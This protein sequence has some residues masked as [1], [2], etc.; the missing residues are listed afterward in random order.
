MSAS[1]E[2]DIKIFKTRK[3]LMTDDALIQD[4]NH[5]SNTFKNALEETLREGAK[6]LLQQAIE[7]EVD[8][9]IEMFKELKGNDNKRFVIRNGYLPQRV[10]QTGIGPIDVKQPR[11]RDKRNG[12]NFNSLIL[13]KYARKTPSI[14]TVIPTLYLKGISTSDFTDALEA[15]LGENAKGLSASTICRLKDSWVQEFKDWNQRDLSE[16]HYVYIWADGIYFNVRLTDDRPCVLVL[17]GALACGRK[18]IISIHDGER[19]STLSWK[20]VLLSLKRRGLSKAP[21]LAVG[22][23]SLGFW[24]A[25]EEVFPETKHQRCW[26]HK[27]A[28]ILDKMSKKVQGAAKKMI[29]EMYL[30]DTKED[31]MKVFNDFIELYEARYPRACDCLKKDKDQLFTFYNFPA[32]HWQHIRTT[33][34]IESTFATVRHRSRQTKGCGSREATLSMVF[35]LIMSAQKRWQR[36][37]GSELIDKVVRGVKF[38]NGEEK[39]TQEKVA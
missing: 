21:L 23:G 35:K 39:G 13:P 18:E 14:E 20:E 5:P 8:E 29:Q 33:N 31:A 2:G 26:V 24:K 11:V 19:E 32:I 7:Y 15:I 3:T 37:R 38:V 30:S 12:H 1:S 16:K 9:Y 10:V 28:N 27:T 22:D 25:L 36:L 4:K 34:P 6:K 17:I